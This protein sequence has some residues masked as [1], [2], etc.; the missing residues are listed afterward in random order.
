MS[1][2]LA[3]A[4]LSLSTTASHVGSP[5]LEDAAPGAFA[6]APGVG[7]EEIALPHDEHAVAPGITACPHVAQ[8]M[9]LWPQ[10]PQNWSPG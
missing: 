1:N 8:T 10:P 5:R 9:R 2:S 6:A 4:A 3:S 7:E